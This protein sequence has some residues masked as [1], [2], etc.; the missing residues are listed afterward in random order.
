[1]Y[2]RRKFETAIQEHLT[3]LAQPV[4]IGS[5]IDLKEI[6]Q[7]RVNGCWDTK[8]MRCN[9]GL[10]YMGADADSDTKEP[11]P[12]FRVFF[13]PTPQI[14]E[15][16]IEDEDANLFP[17]FSAFK[18]AKLDK[19]IVD[20]GKDA[21]LQWV[22]QEFQKKVEL[23]DE[24]K[25]TWIT[26]AG[27]KHAINRI[28]TA[29]GLRDEDIVDAF[30]EICGNR[31]GIPFEDFKRLKNRFTKAGK[32]KSGVTNAVKAGDIRFGPL[33]ATAKMNIREKVL[34]PP[35]D[36]NLEMN[37]WEV[38]EK[39]SPA[40]RAAKRAERCV[41][42]ALLY[43]HGLASEAMNCVDY[44]SRHD[45]LKVKENLLLVGQQQ[46]YNCTKKIK[47]YLMDNLGTFKSSWNMICTDR[48][49]IAISDA[50]SRRYTGSESAKIEE[51]FDKISK[52]FNLEYKA[53]PAETIN[54]KLA[55]LKEWLTGLSKSGLKCH[56]GS[57]YDRLKAKECWISSGGG[58]RCDMCD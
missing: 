40:T 36:L 46:V 21:Q 25:H 12:P 32:I 51:E 53:R 24:S 45:I 42:A 41:F 14:E 39:V 22:F 50:L 19:Q 29:S 3:Q 54:Q 49:K 8:G 43:H 30:R 38:S 47:T 5:S 58:A 56:C 18:I 16:N 31:N 13:D 55:L 6:G 7:F 44:L 11:E 2:R 23:Y 10:C 26:V 35:G 27:F 34:M 4:A 15:N 28:A 52:D 33:K 57:H 37:E 9:F 48:S 20:T 1:M 17:N